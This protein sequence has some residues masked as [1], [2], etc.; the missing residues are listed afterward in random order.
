[1]GNMKQL[2]SLGASF[3]GFGGLTLPSYRFVVIMDGIPM[4]MFT[5][6]TLPTL[7]VTTQDI[8]EGGQNNYIHKLPVR[9]DAGTLT[10][11]R[12]VTSFM[13]FLEWYQFVLDGDVANAKK[14]VMVIFFNVAHIPTIVWNFR[15][16]Y[17]IKWSGPQL[18]SDSQAIAVEELELVHHGF[19]FE[20][21]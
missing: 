10:L 12:G 20:N 1:M 3:F 18:S 5:E 11:K 6:V 14:Q 2:A 4:G 15:D 9:V 21:F 13:E 16:C 19:E 7:S 8:T 17:P